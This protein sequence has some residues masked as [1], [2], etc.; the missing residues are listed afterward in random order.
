MCVCVP[1][2]LL[3]GG[4]ELQTQLDDLVLGSGE[5]TDPCQ[6]RPAKQN[7]EQNETTRT[8]P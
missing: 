2:D 7:K 3:D 8:V 5:V 4:G 6:R 1:T